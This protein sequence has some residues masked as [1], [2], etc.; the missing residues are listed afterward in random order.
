MSRGAF[1][2]GM[3]MA[4]A[5]LV[6]ASM[7]LADGGPQLQ[8]WSQ[9]PDDNN[10]DIMSR[11]RCVD[12]DGGENTSTKGDI[13]IFGKKRWGDTCINP[14]QLQEGFCSDR[15]SRRYD[16]KTIRCDKGCRHGAC[17]VKGPVVDWSQTSVVGQN[18]PT[19]QATTTTIRPRG[20]LDTDGG[21]NPQM[22][23][24]VIYDTGAYSDTCISTSM[25]QEGICH[26][27]RKNSLYTIHIY[28]KQGCNGGACRPERSLFILGKP[29]TAQAWEDLPQHVTTTTL[30]TYQ[31]IDDC[32]DTDGGIEFNIAGT[33]LKRGKKKYKDTCISPS[34]LQEGYCSIRDDDKVE[35]IHRYCKMGC[36]QG[37]CLKSG[38]LS[39][40]TGSFL[41]ES[42]QFRV[43]R[44]KITT[45]TTTLVPTGITCVDTDGGINDG[46]KGDIYVSDVKVWGD[47]CLNPSQ[48]QEGYCAPSRKGRF[49]FRTIYCKNGCT[50][51]ACKP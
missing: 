41:T 43:E 36:V 23:G 16:T 24:D 29:S 49:F 20:C 50:L 38:R 37:A 4:C 15:N 28:C 22:K 12:T 6:S 32:V 8:S 19:T 25:L 17:I 44:P 40:M 11:K 42:W 45:T 18:L 13:L 21:E 1:I 3:I 9:T 26:P 33:V 39:T 7:V 27:S 35:I 34:M 31:I 2:C 30:Q 46:E 51:G 5:L 48:L 47:A 14:S 10:L